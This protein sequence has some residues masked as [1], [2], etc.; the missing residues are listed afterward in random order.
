MFCQ[1]KKYECVYYIY[2]YIYTCVF[3]DD[4]YSYNNSKIE[5]ILILNHEDVFVVHRFCKKSEHEVCV[6][7]Q[8]FLLFVA[9]SF[10]GE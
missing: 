2:N 10:V 9:N 7:V 3:K 1:D 8:T 6:C 4:I 5:Y